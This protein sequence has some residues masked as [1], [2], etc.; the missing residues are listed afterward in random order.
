MDELALLADAD[1]RAHA[2]LAATNERRAFPDAAALAGL[3]AFERAELADL[4]VRIVAQRLREHVEGFLALDHRPTQ[5]TRLVVLLE[6]R[7]IVRP[8]AEMPQLFDHQ[9]RRTCSAGLDETRPGTADE[10]GRR[11]RLVSAHPGVHHEDVIAEV[12]S[13]RVHGLHPAPAKPVEAAE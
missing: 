12:H 8:D 3:A 10:V 6:R 7:Q 13:V 11:D 5:P 9:R 4:D 2:Y 1:R